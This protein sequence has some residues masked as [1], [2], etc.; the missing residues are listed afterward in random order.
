MMASD[1]TVAS[2]E[3]RFG[4]PEVTIGVS[5]P[6]E[7]LMLP[8]IVGLNRARAMFYTGT[9]L[10]AEEALHVGLVHEVTAP[11]ECVPRA[12]KVA[13]SLA[14]LPAEGFVVQKTLL[15][16]FISS[17]SLAAAIDASRYATSLQ[18]AT[19][20]TKDALGAFVGRKR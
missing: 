11:D 5:A 2:A 6:L 12:T 3:A 1:Y 17:G 8:W 9:Q 13:Q 15:Y 10:D 19:D 4:A 14:A 20:D 7:G 18:F 16:Q